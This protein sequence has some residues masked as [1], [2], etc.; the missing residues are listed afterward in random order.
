M[1]ANVDEEK[2]AKISAS[3]TFPTRS[4]KR[5]AN[6]WTTNLLPFLR[7]AASEGIH[8]LFIEITA[9]LTMPTKCST[10]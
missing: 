6:R 8:Q 9:I 4:V 10:I 5:E 1:Q 3:N 7:K 2:E